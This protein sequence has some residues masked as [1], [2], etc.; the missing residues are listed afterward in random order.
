MSCPARP[1]KPRSTCRAAGAYTIVWAAAL[2]ERA[3]DDQGTLVA[4]PQLITSKSPDG[5]DFASEALPG[6]RPAEGELIGIAARVRDDA[7]HGQGVRLCAQHVAD[8][9]ARL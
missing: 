1:V 8:R 6:S 5:R 2:V 3:P 9:C 7:V 4:L